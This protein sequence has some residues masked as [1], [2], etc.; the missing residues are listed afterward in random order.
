MDDILCTGERF[1][2]KKL[3]FL[4]LIFIFIFSFA[5]CVT[6]QF[7][8]QPTVA[9]LQSYAQT[10]AP[11]MQSTE[12]VMQSTVPVAQTVL[13]VEQTTQAL[14]QVQTTQAAVGNADAANW[15][16]AEIVAFLNTSV[17]RAKSNVQPYVLKESSQHFISMHNINSPSMQSMAQ[18]AVLPRGMVCRRIFPSCCRLP[19]RYSLCRNRKSQLQ[20]HRM[21]VATFCLS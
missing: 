3:S 13:P 20:E 17:G 4:C 2:V 5:G 9:D 12:P 15:S 19:E 6:L 10:T 18:S 21:T 16:L 11:V 14:Q 1:S 8:Q 7:E